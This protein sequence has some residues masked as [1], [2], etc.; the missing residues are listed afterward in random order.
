MIDSFNPALFIDASLGR[1]SHFCC[2]QLDS[3][4]TPDRWLTIIATE[5]R[6]FIG[7]VLNFRHIVDLDLNLLPTG[8]FVVRVVIHIA[9]K[10]CGHARTRI[11]LQGIEPL[12]S[13]SAVRLIGFLA[14]RPH[15]D[16]NSMEE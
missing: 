7:T 16:S 4:L 13:R 6:N 12:T 2:D 14:I 1:R 9:M 10:H 8:R 5:L 11:S 3:N 15:L